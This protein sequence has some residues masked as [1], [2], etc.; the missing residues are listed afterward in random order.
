MVE[1]YKRLLGRVDAL[2]G[3]VFGTRAR[4]PTGEKATVLVR[5]LGMAA[6]G[7]LF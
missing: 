7:R 6:K 3:D 5:G 1:I 4:V 2:D